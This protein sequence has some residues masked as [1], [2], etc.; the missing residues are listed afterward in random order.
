[1]KISSLLTALV[2]AAAP[3]FGSIAEFSGTPSKVNGV[4]VYPDVKIQTPGDAVPLKL[5]GAGVGKQKISFIT[6]NAYVAASYVEDVDVLR[7][8]KSPLEGVRAS[9]VKALRLTMLWNMTSTQCRTAFE[10]ALLRND[11]D[12][13]S[14]PVA[15]I[16]NQFDTDMKRGDSALLIGYPKGE[17]LEQL[18]IELSSK[19]IQE[20][21]K[22]LA[23][24][25]WQGWFGKGDENLPALTAA[26]VGKPKPQN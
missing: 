10:E 24:T 9:K 20:A 6:V 16:L 13:A 17:S 26:L 22:D 23:F 8:A 12:L 3:A 2:F 7:A 14:P 15:S 4:T 11:V 25:F 1:M 21:G 5:S 18:L 19:T